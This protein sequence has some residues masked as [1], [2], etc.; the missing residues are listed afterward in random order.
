MKML[1][2]FL[3]VSVVFAILTYQRNSK[4][5]ILDPSVNYVILTGGPGGGKST[6]I[7][8]LRKRGYLCMDEVARDIIKEEVATNGKALPWGDRE[9]FTKRI[10][11]E[12]IKQ[13]H[14]VN[15]CEIVFFDRGI[16]DVLAYA[17][18]VNVKISKGMEWAAKELPFNKRV[19][20]TLPWKEIYCN[21]EERKQSFEEAI[22]TFERI[23]K[24][25]R[26][27]GYEVVELPKADVEIRINF[28]L[29]H[30]GL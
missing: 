3:I 15:S 19:F 25:Y 21:D 17:K 20:V 27:Y 14:S 10:F 5:T 11:D 16:V 6:L 18:M 12:T 29:K 24:E 13:Y 8:A 30:L 22:D 9:K 23:V 7:E 28:I 26:K 1:K 4:M 2:Y